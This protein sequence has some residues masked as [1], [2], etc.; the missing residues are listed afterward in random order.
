MSTAALPRSGQ[1]NSGG[2]GMNAIV[3]LVRAEIRKLFTTRAVPVTVAIATVLAVGSVLIDA[4]VA[5]HPGQHPLG[6]ITET[7]QML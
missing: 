3:R 1:Q 4:A 7:N 6:S 5:G 2:Y